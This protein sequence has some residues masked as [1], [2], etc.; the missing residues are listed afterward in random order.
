MAA[1]FTLPGH[2]WPRQLRLGEGQLR[3]PHAEP[4][5]VR[6][7]VGRSAEVALRRGLPA[8]AAL[9]GRGDVLTR[10]HAEGGNAGGANHAERFAGEMLRRG[11]TAAAALVG[12]GDIAL[13]E[14]AEYVTLGAGTLLFLP[15]ARNR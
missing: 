1:G 13:R 15:R 3:L 10:Q 8:A 14:Q 5:A 12:R 9:V 7:A 6:A 4:A 11:L 2:P